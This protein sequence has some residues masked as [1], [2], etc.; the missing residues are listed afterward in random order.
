M[1]FFV[2]KK[3]ISTLQYFIVSVCS[4]NDKNASDSYYYF[5]LGFFVPDGG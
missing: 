5:A 4:D 1:F 2:N 3:Y